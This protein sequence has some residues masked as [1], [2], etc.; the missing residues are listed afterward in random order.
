[1]TPISRSPYPLSCPPDPPQ[2]PQDRGTHIR[3]SAKDEHRAPTPRLILLI[4]QQQLGDADLD[5]RVTHVI[6]GDM[7]REGKM[8]RQGRGE[9]RPL[10]R[11][12]GRFGREVQRV[13]R[14][15]GRRQVGQ[16]VLDCAS[17][18]VKGGFEE[19]VD[20]I[21]D[22]HRIRELPPGRNDALQAQRIQHSLERLVRFEGEGEGR[23]ALWER[24]VCAEVGGGIVDVREL[25]L[26][27]PIACVAGGEGAF[28]RERDT[29]VLEHPQ[30]SLAQDERGHRAKRRAVLQE[31]GEVGGRDKLERVEDELHGQ[32]EAGA[33]WRHGLLG[34]G[35]WLGVHVECGAVQQQYN[36]KTRRTRQSERRDQR[37]GSE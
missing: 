30:E 32:A 1:M 34:L 22:R 23:A 4:D 20:P 7:V 13:E 33:R 15:W 35:L 14:A 29:R 3:S 21:Q 6:P 27:P 24:E 37:K 28:E 9:M 10:A 31:A 16:G 19:P 2:H 8:R 17:D 12:E 5:A 18:G 36:T 26:L 11:G 25:E